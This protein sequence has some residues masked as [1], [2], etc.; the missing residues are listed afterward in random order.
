[1]KG[2]KEI[3]LVSEAALERGSDFCYLVIAEMKYTVPGNSPPL[4]SWPRVVRRVEL[5]SDVE[6]QLVQPI[7]ARRAHGDAHGA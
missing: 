6:A 5:P 7:E 4:E 3:S 1:M 2:A